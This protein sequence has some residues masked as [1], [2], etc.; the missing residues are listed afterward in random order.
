M[1]LSFL[2]QDTVDMELALFV[3]LEPHD[4]SLKCCRSTMIILQS[5]LLFEYVGR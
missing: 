3:H 5:S 2:L 4:F 1:R